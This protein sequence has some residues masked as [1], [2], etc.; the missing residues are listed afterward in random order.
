MAGPV[1]WGQD[2][3]LQWLCTDRLPFPRTRHIRNPW[4]HDREI[5]VP[6]D[7]AE[8]EPS[9]GQTLL[10]EWRLHPVSEGAGTT[11]ILH[12]APLACLLTTL[13]VIELR[14]DSRYLRFL[15]T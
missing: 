15:N 5:K 11:G 4:N 8:L 2:F 9:V 10:E 7:G 12:D 1:G 14:R 6:R 3:K 13:R